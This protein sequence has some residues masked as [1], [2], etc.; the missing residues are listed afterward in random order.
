[1]NWK[2]IIPHVLAI[3]IFLIVAL[4]YCKPALE[5]KVLQQSDITQWKA[6]SKDIYN[7]KEATGE[8]PLWTNSMFSGMPGYLIAGK[9]NNYI[10]YYFT[11]ALSLFLPKPF[12]FFFLACICFY[13]LS[14]CL[15]VNSWVGVIGSL[16]YAYATYN[17][18][19]VAAGH[20]TKMLSIA[21]L[22][23]FIGS[24][25]LI[26]ERRYWL[27]AGLT[28][29]FTGAL[30]SQNHY[31]IVYYGI[32]AAFFMSVAFGIRWIMQKDYKH[33]I[34]ALSFTVI[35]GLVGVFSN[36]VVIFPNYEYTKETIRGG[37]ELADKTSKIGKEGLSKD[38]AFSYSMYMS[39]PFVM[40]VPKMFG[41]SSDQ[42]ELENEKSKAVEAI[43]SM[44]QEL[45]QQIQNNL[46]YYWGGIGGT[47]GPPYTGAIICFLAILG[48]IVLDNKHKW[49][50]AATLGLTIVMSWGGYFEGVNTWLLNNLPM[51]NK[52]RAPSMIIVVPTFLLCF[53][54]ILSLQKVFFEID[55]NKILWNYLK[56]AL[57]A[58]AGV[59]AILFFMYFTFDYQ[60]SE[61]KEVVKQLAQLNNEQISQY[62]KGFLNGLKE[63]RMSLFFNSL[64]RSLFFIAIAAGAIWL[65]QRKFLK[66]IFALAVIGT[67]SFIDVMAVNITYL[68]SENF[69]EKEENEAVFTPSQLDL[70]I[71]QDK[72]TYR[73][74]NV[75]QGVQTA[76]NHGAMTSYFHRSIGGYHPAKLSIYQDLI[77]KQLYNFPKCQPVLDMLNCKYII[78]G[79]PQQPQVQVNS[80]ALGDAW[81]VKAVKN[82]STAKEEMDAL[83]NLKVADTVLVN[84]SYNKIIKNNFQFDSTAS[85]K[86]LSNKNDIVSYKSVSKTS[87]PAVFSEVYYN[88]GWNAYVNGNKVDYARVNYVL[89]GLMVPAGENTIEFKFEPESHALGWKLTN[90]A[91]LLIIILLSA[92]FWFDYK[93]RKNK[94]A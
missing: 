8:V 57:M 34:T 58:T 11:E 14:Q 30:I 17:P 82:T 22:P 81:F 15:K 6:M 35:A 91:S 25:I 70:Q 33:L 4:I 10:P 79:D 42:M 38:Y 68:N 86:L 53:L 55:D 76:F 56:K 75:T 32:I 59:F 47:S 74:I 63:D 65:L 29:M 1:M 41:G 20:D 62:V 85:I 43:Q 45:A 46:R 18:I 66:P 40:L 2:K 94:L 5:G 50:I 24:L 80:T 27:G 92:G 39:E 73:V 77:E 51:Y 49:W 31:Q 64:L 16:A 72:S 84:N 37:S 12:Q 52:F 26:F 88:K 71:M 28:A 89:R 83:T 93:D 61:D 36:A 23:G 87:M 44:P 21:L 9:A 67:F 78:Y 19:I 90:I 48:F 54:A 13:I 7:V 69:K 60:T 3:A